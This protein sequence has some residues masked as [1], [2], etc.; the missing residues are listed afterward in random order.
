MVMQDV[1]ELHIVL[2]IEVGK[3]NWRKNILGPVMPTRGMGYRFNSMSSEEF[4]VKVKFAY[5]DVAQ[6]VR[7]YEG[8][9]DIIWAEADLPKEI[10]LSY[11]QKAGFEEFSD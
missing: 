2:C 3:V 10:P 7:Q 11:L 1:K 4:I 9:A 5:C 6:P 8:Q